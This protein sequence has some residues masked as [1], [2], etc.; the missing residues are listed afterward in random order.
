MQKY[1]TLL[2]LAAWL[3]LPA[4]AS[5][6]V[7]FDAGE[8]TGPINAP[9]QVDDNAPSSGGSLLL[10]L[11]LGASNTIDNT[12]TP[13]SFVSGT[14]IILAAGGF[15]NNGGTNETLTTFNFTSSSAGSDLALRWFPQLTLAQYQTG[16]LTLAG[17][18][19]G[20][21]TPNPTGSAPD[22]GN[23]WIIPADGSTINLDLFTTNSDG[24]GT[25]SAAAG[26]A[27]FLVEIQNAPEPSVSGLFALGLLVLFW[28]ARHRKIN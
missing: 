17:D 24:G 6:T 13:G 18:Y 1:L 15:N 21:Y 20:T 9:M 27:P 4:R 26:S 8:L 7:N 10:L 19:F 16:S 28:L 11:N 23:N 25:Q 14:N 22:G 12:I 3:A 5:I 2:A